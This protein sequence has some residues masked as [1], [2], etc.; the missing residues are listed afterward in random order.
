MAIDK[1]LQEALALDAKDRGELVSALLRSLEPD[2]E[3]LTQEE[4]DVAWKEEL[5]RRAKAIDEGR[6]TLLSHDEVFQ[7]LRS[8]FPKR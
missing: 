1:V 7:R 3:E 4:W 5:E 2:D 8:R 6:A